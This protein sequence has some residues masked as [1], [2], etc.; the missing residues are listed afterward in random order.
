MFGS[1]RGGQQSQPPPPSSERDSRISCWRS[2]WEPER[3]QDLL[4]EMPCNADGEA[5]LRS[6]LF[7][8]HQALERERSTSRELRR[9]AR[10][11]VRQARARMSRE[12]EQDLRRREDLL[13]RRHAAEVARI[14]HLAEQERRLEEDKL[15]A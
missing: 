14:R 3:Q 15:T 4:T 1:L 10:E 13:G 8:A 2:T 9:G 7:H 12:H 11:Q 5:D 6:E